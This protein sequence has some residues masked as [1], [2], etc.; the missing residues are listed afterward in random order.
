MNAVLRP[1]AAA[2]LTL[3][4]AAAF[5]SPTVPLTLDLIYT[6]GKLSAGLPAA[7]TVEL[8]GVAQIDNGDVATAQ[9]VD[10]RKFGTHG[11]VAALGYT[12]VFGPAWLAT[13]TVAAGHG[14]AN[15][16]RLRADLELGRKW[17]EAGSVVTRIAAFHAG[18][19]GNRSDRGLRLGVAGYLPGG[20][21]LEG[22][23]TYNISDPGSVRSTMPFVAATL[24]SEGRQYLSLRVASGQEG[25]QAL[26]ADQQ[27]V[28]FHSSSAGLTFKRWLGTRWGIDAQAEWYRN[29]SYRRISAGGGMFAQF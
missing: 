12:R 20:L 1:A 24:G 4:A 29:P 27:L 15:W 19:D 18:Y 26:G 17:G 7:D 22:G 6:H 21:V 2:V 5:A 16:A 10:E 28:G 8:R 3:A 9:L 14:G 25:Y 13:G 11:G 23:A